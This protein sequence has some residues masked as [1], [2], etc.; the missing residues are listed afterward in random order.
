MKNVV[1]ANPKAAAGRVQSLWDKS[2]QAMEARL[3]PVLYFRDALCWRLGC[4]G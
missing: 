4:C 3:G 2:R 1:V